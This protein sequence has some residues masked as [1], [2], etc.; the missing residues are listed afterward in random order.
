MAIDCGDWAE[1]SRALVGD[2][3]LMAALSE[4]VAGAKRM[5]G[6][7]IPAGVAGLLQLVLYNAE[8][9]FFNLSS[10]RELLVHP[11]GVNA[12]LPSN[13]LLLPGCPDW[14]DVLQWSQERGLTSSPRLPAL[15]ALCS[16]IASEVW[17]QAGVATRFLLAVPP[18]TDSI[19][20]RMGLLASDSLCLTGT[21]SRS[22]H[23]TASW[24]LRKV[25]GLKGECLSGKD[26]EAS[27]LQS[28]VADGN[29]V[30]P[31]L[32]PLAG[33]L[34]LDRSRKRARREVM[35]CLDA[36]NVEHL[37]FPLVMH[38]ADYHFLDDPPSVRFWRN[39]RG[40]LNLA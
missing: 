3:T 9:S 18:R 23:E 36:A 25:Y 7:D 24:A 22:S 38:A 1:L 11:A 34:I 12:S 5:I 40:F 39:G 30:L 8:H 16:A 4:P 28:L 10:T 32:P 29:G 13:L 37:D 26:F 19:L 15:S 6:C 21:S 14:D 20:C 2:S 31:S 35:A 27:S 17:H 33:A